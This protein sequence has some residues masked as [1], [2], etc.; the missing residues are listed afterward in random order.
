MVE[1]SPWRA[2]GVLASAGITFVVA[3]AGGAL[4]GYFLDRWLGISPWLTLIGLGVGIAAGFRELF[5]T[6]KA[7]ER[8]GRD[9]Q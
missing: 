5:R 4:L 7:A 1:P 6:I 9:G 8:Q 3:T 2:L